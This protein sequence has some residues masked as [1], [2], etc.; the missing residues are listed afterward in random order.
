M[1]TLKIKNDKG[2]IYELTHNYAQYYVTAVEGLTPPTATINTSTVGGTD[3]VFYN[4]SRLQPRNIVIT[5][6]LEGDIESNRQKLYT[7]FP[8]KKEIEVCYINKNR[9][10]K[11]R[12]YV[13]SIEGSI[14]TQ[15]EQMQISI[16]CPRPYFEGITTIQ[17]EISRVIPLFEFPFSLSEPVPISE[18]RRNPVSYVE[19][20][21]DVECGCIITIKVNKEISGFKIT[22]LFIREYFS[23]S[24]FAFEKGDVVT[25]CTI[26][27]KLCAIVNRSSALINLLPYVDDGSKWFE[28]STGTNAFTYVSASGNMDDLTV[29]LE[30]VPLYGGV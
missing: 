20:I 10:V 18:L 8:L 3:G 25:I 1:F 23:I 21:G 14:F 13:E 26:K 27:G 17:S 15:Q 9:N 19:N 24:N 22:N 28:L 6:V 29:N 7:V 2:D 5:V 4:S 30:F 12:G 16:I 11:I